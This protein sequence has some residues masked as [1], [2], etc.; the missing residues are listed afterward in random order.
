MVEV[1][2]LT[3]L[4]TQ[5]QQF[6]KKIDSASSIRL[7][8]VAKYGYTVDLDEPVKQSERKV[9]LTLRLKDVDGKEVHRITETCPLGHLRS[10]AWLGRMTD[11]ALKWVLTSESPSR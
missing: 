8:T 4:M 6:P 3:N 5:R 2:A 11:K 1:E 9:K 10:H 7:E